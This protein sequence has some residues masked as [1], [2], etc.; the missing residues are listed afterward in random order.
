MAHLRVDEAVQQLAVGH[1]AAADSCADGQVD[2]SIQTL[3]RAPAI[4]PQGGAVDVGIEPDRYSQGAADSAGKI[5]VGPASLGV[6]V[7]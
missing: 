5:A 1:P 6:V 3:G 7:M 2:K 4:L